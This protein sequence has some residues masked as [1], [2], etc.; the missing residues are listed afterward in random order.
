[1]DWSTS[2]SRDYVWVSQEDRSAGHF[3]DSV[4]TG[5]FTLIL[6]ISASYQAW[7]LQ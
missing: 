6:H 4:V 2:V 7:H 5:T 1:M 3:I